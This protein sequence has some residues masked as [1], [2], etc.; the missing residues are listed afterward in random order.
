[1]MSSTITLSYQGCPIAGIFKPT[2]QVLAGTTKQN[3]MLLSV[4]T[5]KA[6]EESPEK[7]VRSR[8]PK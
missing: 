8:Q 5:R 2:D 7:K 4:L 3:S 6:L 1:M